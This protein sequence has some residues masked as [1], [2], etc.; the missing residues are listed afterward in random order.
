MRSTNRTS[1][2]RGAATRNQVGKSVAGVD[3]I[4]VKATI[5]DAQIDSA[6]AHSA[7]AAD[8]RRGARQHREVQAGGADRGLR[9]MGQA[10]GLQAGG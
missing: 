1:N 5:P 10:R 4:E 7:C 6:L 3:A 9:E 8:H 2:K